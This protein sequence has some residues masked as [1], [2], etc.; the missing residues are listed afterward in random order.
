MPWDDEHARAQVARAEE[1]LAGLE[2]L[3][4]SA[5]AARAVETVEALVG[6]YGDCLA[7]VIEYAAETA[8]TDGAG[9][10]DDGTAAGRTGLG[11]LDRLAADE[12]VGHLLLVH[13]LH[14]DPVETRVRRALDEVGRHVRSQGCELEL[15]E[16]SDTAV[17]IRLERRGHGCSSAQEPAEQAVRDAIAGRAPE[18]LDVGIESGPEPVPETLIP[19]EALFHGRT[20]AGRSAG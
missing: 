18:I 11:L 1:L 12:L 2:T 7:R 15:L 20:P 6:L 16:L 17:R 3:P 8:D 4:D 13:D 10:A 5:A 14:P 19:V 9:E